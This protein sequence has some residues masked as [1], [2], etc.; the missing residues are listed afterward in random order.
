[1]GLV[2]RRSLSGTACKVYDFS[3]TR[4][5]AEA[6]VHQVTR[7]LLLPGQAGYHLDCL[8]FERLRFRGLTL[9]PFNVP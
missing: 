8:V 3:I 4:L 1:M 2:L 6:N 5:R 7:L 9:Q